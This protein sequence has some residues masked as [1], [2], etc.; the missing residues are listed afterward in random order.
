MSAQFHTQARPPATGP[1]Q[2]TAP[3]AEGEAEAMPSAGAPA[4]RE[5]LQQAL[6]RAWPELQ[7]Q[8]GLI[9]ALLNL[10]HAHHLQPGQALM[11]DGDTNQAGSLWLLVSGSLS[12]GR[13]D[14]KGVWR[15]SELLESGRWIDLASAWCHAPYPETGLALSPVWA[16]EFP[17]EALLSLGQAHRPLLSLLL[18]GLGRQACAALESRQALRTQDFPVRLAE[19]LLQ[20]QAAQGQSDALVLRQFKRDLAAHLGVT[21]ETLS[22]TLRDFHAQGLIDMHHKVLR[23]PDRARLAALRPSGRSES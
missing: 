16:Q 13:Y 3:A 1:L 20:E 17:A 7:A 9:Q 15:A 21:P 23:I 18:E 5:R 10:G 2:F 19:W 11:Q 8:P 6:L 4:P 22:R 12:V 14:G